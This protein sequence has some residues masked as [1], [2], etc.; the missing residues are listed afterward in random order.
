MHEY[1]IVSSL[2]ER[3]SAEARARNAIAVLRLTVTI[4]AAAGVEPDLLAKAYDL[5]REGTIC[6]DAELLV[7]NSE[8][9]WVCSGCERPIAR[10]EILSCPR[11]GRPARMVS[12]D[13]I[14]LEQIEME[15]P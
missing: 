7:L 10:G 15:V 1:S 4:G 12:G 3:V 9:R 2:V 14:V 8:E 11:C 13:E 5:F 6:A